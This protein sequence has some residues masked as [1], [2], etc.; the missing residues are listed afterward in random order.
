MLHTTPQQYCWKVWRRMNKTCLDDDDDDD[1]DI[2]IYIEA[3]KELVAQSPSNASSNILHTTPQQHCWKVWRRVN[4]T[5]LDDDD[6]IYREY[7]Q[8]NSL[9]TLPQTLPNLRILRAKPK[10]LM[11]ERILVTIL[12]P[13]CIFLATLYVYEVI[14]M[15]CN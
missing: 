5:C 11:R 3:Y 8:W 4:K 6:D 10:R 12:S 2:Y 13:A 7:F 9:L 14:C 1:D 15:A